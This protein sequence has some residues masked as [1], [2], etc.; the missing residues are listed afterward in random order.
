V[1]A[2]IESLFRL[3]FYN[4]IITAFL[5]AYLRLSLSSCE[6]SFVTLAGNM[7]EDER[8]PP[9]DLKLTMKDVAVSAIIFISVALSG[10]I[11]LLCLKMTEE[12]L[13]NF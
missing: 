10:P 2:K 6:K 11:A 8:L 9:G 12:H 3:I 13:G 4:M 1:R 5:K 7:F